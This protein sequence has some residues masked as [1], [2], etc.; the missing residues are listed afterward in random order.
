MKNS[1][2]PSAERANRRYFEQAYVAGRHGWETYEPSSYALAYLNRLR[3]IVPHGRLIDVG[4]GEGRHTIAAARAGFQAVGIDYEPLALER[5]RKFVRAAQTKG[6]T[7]RQA[8]V[9]SLPFPAAYFDIV[10]DYGC[11]H[12]QKKSD[13]PRYTSS[14][15]RIM[16]PRGFFIL[17]VFSPRFRL[18]RGS[19]R[20][21]HIAYGAYRR[22]FTRKDVRAL[23]GP[24][25]KVLELVEERGGGQGFWHALMERRAVV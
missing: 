3:L 10:L 16:K 13:W 14:L 4:C 24:H 15:L 20:P 21:W 7:F 12:H 8:N 9:F 11:L 6:A 2:M 17:S 18:F 5:A 22:F 23:F 19:A 25:F 1:A